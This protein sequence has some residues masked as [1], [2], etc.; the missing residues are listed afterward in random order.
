MRAFLRLLLT[1]GYAWLVYVRARDL[2]GASPLWGAWVIIELSV[3]GI[4]IAILWA[5]VLGEKVSSSLTSTLVE[6]SGIIPRNRLVVWI[7]RL[8]ARGWHRAA[9]FL[10]FCEGIRKPD[11]LHP[12]WLGLQCVQPGSILEK[13]F[14]R[15]VFRHNH[16]NYAVQAWKILRERH[17]CDPSP[18]ACPEV[19][20]VLRR[21]QPKASTV[22]V[23][24]TLPKAPPAVRL[25]R[26]PSIRLFDKPPEACPVA[27]R[28]EPTTTSARPDSCSTPS[29]RP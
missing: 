27:S 23:P 8:Q 5:P 17:G 28:V 20:V 22:Q 16:V 7:S 4:V 24:V 15:E 29:E 13:W 3:T 6:D 26:N 9:L 14:A 11:A 25:P 19:E 18:H 1:A 2:A 10:C 12:A 21:L